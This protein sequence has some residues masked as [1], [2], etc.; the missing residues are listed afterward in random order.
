[1]LEA[2][3]PE[4]AIESEIAAKEKSDLLT[5]TA[6]CREV[7]NLLSKEERVFCAL[8]SEISESGYGYSKPVRKAEYLELAVCDHFRNA[9]WR[10]EKKTRPH[11][12]FF[13]RKVEYFQFSV[14]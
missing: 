5:I 6:S 8:F 4:E 1:M 7:S 3:T 10:V 11:K 2:I 13:W 12:L 9:G 14:V